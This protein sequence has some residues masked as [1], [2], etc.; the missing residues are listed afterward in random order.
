MT[1][2]SSCG[3]LSGWCAGLWF[4]AAPESLDDAHDP[5]A[6]RAWFAQGERDD[7]SGV[8][9]FQLCRFRAK[10]R[11]GLRYI[12]FAGRTGQQAIVA[13]VLSHT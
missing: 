4:L 13:E 12:G 3:G 8:L 1:Y 5:A 7:L 9:V 2:V 11:A 10:Q 6:V